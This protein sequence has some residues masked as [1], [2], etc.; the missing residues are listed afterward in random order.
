MFR[1][2]HWCLFSSNFVAAVLTFVSSLLMIIIGP[3]AD[4]AKYVTLCIG[5]MGGA[6]NIVHVYLRPS[7]KA[8]TAM[9]N[10][11]SCKTLESKILVAK[12]GGRRQHRTLAEIERILNELEFDAFRSTLP[13]NA[14]LTAT[15]SPKSEKTPI[16][17]PLED[18]VAIRKTNSDPKHRVPVVRPSPTGFASC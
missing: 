17:I 15:S 2:L 11:I 8:S 18:T 16:Q 3:H 4:A 13:L 12:E 9:S 1:L 10:L 6:T 5:L 14:A 7:V